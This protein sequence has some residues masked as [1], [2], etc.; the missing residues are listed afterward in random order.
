MRLKIFTAILFALGLICSCAPGLSRKT[1]AFEKDHHGFT[2][3]ILL[4][5]ESGKELFQYNAHKAFT[6]ASNTKILS[7]YAAI[8]FLDDSIH[9]FRYRNSKDSLIFS[10]TGDP[11][12]L[13]AE[14]SSSAALEFLRNSRDSIYYQKANWKQAAYGAGWSWDDFKYAFSP[15][16]SAIPV[17]G[18]IVSLSQSNEGLLISPGIFQDSIMYC[19]VNRLEKLEGRNQFMI[20]RNIQKQDTFRVPFKTSEELS[21]QILEQETGRSITMIP[22]GEKASE[23][24]KSIASDSLYKQMM[25]QSDNLIAEQLLIM[26]S[27]KLTD[28]MSTRSAIDQT[29]K[30]LLNDLPDEFQWADGSGLSR[31]NMNSPANLANILQCIWNKKKETWIATIFPTAG[32]DGTLADILTDEDAF[33]FAKSGTLKNNYS[34]SGYLKTNSDRLLIFSIMNSNHLGS[35]KQIKTEISKL[36]IHIRNR[37]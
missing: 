12:L 30:K 23:T 2:G 5:A 22:P 33:V 34:L 24:I 13:N 10:A 25:H 21:I 1:E 15:Q 17:Y 7:L 28:T 37:Y 19:D 16:I 31:Y 9:T 18:N 27:E 6:P 11:G 14:F 29:R 26:I 3:M 20:P 8:H 32:K 36:L 4:D 35:P